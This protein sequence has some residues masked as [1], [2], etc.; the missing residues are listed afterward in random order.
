MIEE[1]RAMFLAANPDLDYWWT[2][3]QARDAAKENT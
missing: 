2:A 3:H 1:T